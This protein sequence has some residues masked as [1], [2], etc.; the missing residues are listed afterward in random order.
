MSG[1][2]RGTS[3]NQSGITTDASGNTL[4]P[5]WD[6]KTRK[7]KGYSVAQGDNTGPSMTELDSVF[8]NKNGGKTSKTKARNSSIVKALK[9]L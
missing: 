1:S 8:D 6:P 2:G 4:F 3:T 9:N 7:V 5:I